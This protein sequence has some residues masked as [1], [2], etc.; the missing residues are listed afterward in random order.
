MQIDQSVVF[1]DSQTLAAA[2]EVVS[3]HVL[4]FGKAYDWQKPAR[5]R[6][7]GTGEAVRIKV[8]A[9]EAIT[10]DE[11]AANNFEIVL[12]TSDAEAFG[13]GVV[14]LFR[15]PV[16]DGMAKNASYWFL[17]PEGKVVKDYLR[18]KFVATATKVFT[19]GKVFAHMA[20]A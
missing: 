17:L 11:A 14:E 9:L 13:S 18:L 8:S 16:Q 19:A 5:D 15:S 3:E 10:T 4:N 1:C 12:E 20:V 7:L 2:N 6:D